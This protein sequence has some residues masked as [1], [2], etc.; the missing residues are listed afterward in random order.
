MNDAY[1]KLRNPLPQLLGAF[2]ILFSSLGFVQ[3]FYSLTIERTPL[4]L[5]ITSILII[6]ISIA[7]FFVLFLPQ[8]KNHEDMKKS[9]F[10][11]MVLDVLALYCIVIGL[12]NVYFFLAA[13]NGVDLTIFWIV[14]II[15]MFVGLLSFI[16][17]IYLLINT[18]FWLKDKKKD[19]QI[20]GKAIT[21]IIL[22]LFSLVVVIQ[23]IIEYFTIPNIN[24][25]K[26][27]ILGIGG[28]MPFVYF[29]IMM[30]Y[31]HYTQVLLNYELKDADELFE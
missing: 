9:A 13:E 18:P 7:C 24:E 23:K 4:Y 22:F 2:S 31:I 20:F 26:F 14:G 5:L 17:G 1:K 11:L 3:Y 30:L 10:K 19:E 27:M 12:Y 6:I 16:Y 8:P 29:V 21:I 15:T 28:M 25:S